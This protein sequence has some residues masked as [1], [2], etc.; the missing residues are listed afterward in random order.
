MPSRPLLILGNMIAITVTIAAF[1][2]AVSWMIAGILILVSLVLPLLVSVAPPGAK[3]TPN[4]QHRSA[5]KHS[6]TSHQSIMKTESKPSPKQQALRPPQPGSGQI[7][8]SIGAPHASSARTTLPSKVPLVIEGPD[9]NPIIATDD[10]IEYDVDL[11]A[12]KEFLG[13]VTADGLVNVYLLDEDNMDNL[14]EGE[15]FWS[16]TGEESVETAK[17]EFTAPSRGT[18]FFVVENADDRAITATVKIQ[19]E[20]TFTDRHE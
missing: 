1:A 3:F 13:E 11:E 2:Q 19:K 12:G 15:E 20:S 18:W 10:Y 17:L 9:L 14:D 6:L 5:E 8:T 7:G 4:S 16:E